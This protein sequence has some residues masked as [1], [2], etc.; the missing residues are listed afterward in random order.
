MHTN[1]HTHSY[2]PPITNITHTHILQK[3]KKQ[4]TFLAA[5]EGE[6][7]LEKAAAA[8]A[9][10]GGSGK[11]EEDGG[12]REVEEEEEGGGSSS[13]LARSW[14][15]QGG[16]GGGEAGWPAA[17]AGGVV[18]VSCT[19]VCRAS[20]AARAPREKL[21]PHTLLSAQHN[22][23]CTGREVG[24]VL[25]SCMRVCTSMCYMHVHC[26]G[27]YD[28]VCNMKSTKVQTSHLHVL[29]RCQQQAQEFPGG[30]Y[31]N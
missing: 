12:G 18:V 22:W 2:R 5:L 8:A 11:E 26:T 21:P 28:A 25:V 24:G 16:G 13:T 20:L 29:L 3:T 30:P 15:L 27:K 4:P 10:V 9:L 14:R 23:S 6:G 31:S 7:A 1:I 19:E 17:S